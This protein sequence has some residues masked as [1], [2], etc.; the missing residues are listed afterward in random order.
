MPELQKYKC[1]ARFHVSTQKYFAQLN[2]CSP[3]VFWTLFYP[4]SNS[5]SIHCW[6]CK[7][8]PNEERKR[9]L[10][11][12]THIQIT[13]KTRWSNFKTMTDKICSTYFYLNRTLSP[14]NSFAQEVCLEFYYWPPLVCC[15]KQ[16]LGC[17]NYFWILQFC[18]PLGA[19]SSF[20][21][22]CSKVAENMPN[23][24]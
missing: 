5:I 19:W 6:F 21:E 12:K 24:R 14:W 18:T 4:S 1:Q 16:R 11:L 15:S 3:T 7:R 10:F 13:R 23:G 9:L 2:T 20:N 22:L 8:P 17:G